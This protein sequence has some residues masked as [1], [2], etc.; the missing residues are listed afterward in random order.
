[1]RH[2]DSPDVR[3]TEAAAGSV[4]TSRR[5][6]PFLIK[7]AVTAGVI[8][9]LLR[10]VSL[11]DVGA[12]LAGASVAWLAAGVAA[13]LALRAANAGRI[14]LIARSQQVPLSYGMILRTLFTTAFYGLLLPGTIG[15][16]AATLVKYV[17]HGATWVAALASMVI[18]RLLDLL[19]SIALAL[20]F[21]GLDTSR[22]P[23]SSSALILTALLFAPLLLFGGHALLFRGARLFEHEAQW[24]SH[25][26]QHGTPGLRHHAIRFLHQC[27]QGGRLTRSGA[28]AVFG[29]SVGKELLAALIAVCFARAI[30]I[31]LPFTTIAWMQAA[32]G[33]AVLLPLSV[34]GLGVREGMLLLLGQS[35]GLSPTQALGWGVLQSSAVLLMAGIGGLLEAQTHWLRARP[36]T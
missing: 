17:G 15:A 29:L 3:C 7:L 28:V 19:T 30:G 14:R 22:R 12:V 35:Q 36:A 24:L 21:W 23:A 2:L 5:Y 1:M 31:T 18:N 8:W 13:Q 32:V 6:V 25:G 16:G 9:M 26:P 27:A 4:L 34:S 33:L 10:R 20:S 11:G